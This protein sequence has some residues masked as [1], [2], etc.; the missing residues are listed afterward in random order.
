MT[1]IRIQILQQQCKAPVESI[2]WGEEGEK[3]IGGEGGERIK[4]GE[5]VVRLVMVRVMVAL[6]RVI[7][8]T[9]IQTQIP[10]IHQMMVYERRKKNEQES[11]V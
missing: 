6:S 5:G 9:Q 11:R 8:L 4:G 7:R 2:L 1:V 10:P 3:I